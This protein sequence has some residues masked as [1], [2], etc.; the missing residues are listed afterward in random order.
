MNLTKS[1][2]ISTAAT[3]AFI[4]S[5]AVL[6]L[7]FWVQ[8][9]PS[10]NVPKTHAIVLS[11]QPE[12]TLDEFTIRLLGNKLLSA[13]S[14]D[15]NS[16]YLTDAERIVGCVSSFVTQNNSYQPSS[17]LATMSLTLTLEDIRQL[18]E[19]GALATAGETRFSQETAKFICDSF[20]DLRM[21]IIV[22]DAKLDVIVLEAIKYMERVFGK[23]NSVHQL[24]DILLKKQADREKQIQSEELFSNLAN[25]TLLLITASVLFGVFLLLMIYKRTD[26]MGTKVAHLDRTM[27]YGA[28]AVVSEKKKIENGR[29]LPTGLPVTDP[30]QLYVS[31]TDVNTD[32]YPQ[33]ITLTVA[34]P[35]STA[36]KA[37]AAFSYMNDANEIVETSTSEIF[38]VPAYGE[39]NVVEFVPTNKDSL[40]KWRSEI[41]PA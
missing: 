32:T 26:Q 5:I 7:S 17:S 36:K 14:P 24:N 19:H 22:K 31:M 18:I 40:V 1:I 2:V 4:A 29:G 23:S 12:A 11:K 33:K 27:K 3:L 13:R 25:P 9:D 6:I 16:A 21:Q 28:M 20:A 41:R 10:F 15:P 34:N 8:M 35:S 30:N 37:R 39:F 38:S